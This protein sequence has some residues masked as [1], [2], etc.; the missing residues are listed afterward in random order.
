MTP[1]RFYRP[2]AGS[3]LLF[4]LAIF[5]AWASWFEI[6]QIIRA[7]G[8]V[9]PQ[10]RIQV[11]QAADGGVLEALNVSEGQTVR[12]GQVLASLESKR[13]GA[14]VDEVRNRIAGLEIARLRAQAEANGVELNFGAYRL[15]HPD[16]VRVQLNLHH[17]IVRTHEQEVKTLG[18]HYDLV[19]Q[20][21]EMT[22]KL[23]KA[24][25]VSLV[26]LLRVK[27]MVIE[28]RQN[29]QMA[30]DKF[31]SEARKEL[32][33][34]E[35]EI[36]SQRSKFQER[37]SVYDHTT[38]QAPMDGVVKFMRLNTVGGVLRPG[39]ELMQIVPTDSQYVVEARVNPA[40]VAQLEMGQVA[41]L[42]MDAFDYSLYG[43]LNGKLTYISADT[44]TETGPDGRSNASYYRVRLEVVIP[45]NSRIQPTDIKPGMTVTVDLKVGKRSVL[46][47]L[48]KP[49]AR[50]FSGALGQR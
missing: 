27:K 20:E 16:L 32:V 34:I 30:K 5:I 1:L 13:A 42:R 26:E 22:E 24:D 46:N 43:P 50:G 47:Y 40:D 21:Y 45:P 29:R 15:S 18:E 49:I 6:D 3:L 14:S 2:G 39:D 10:E 36:T 25:D 38:L 48:V 8:Q 44:L 31:L 41:T 33:R 4:T 17:Q 11:I 12:K 23:Y 28:A 35:D 9:I 37:Q 19:L 7:S